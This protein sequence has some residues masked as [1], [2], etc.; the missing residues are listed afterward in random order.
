MEEDL[1]EPFV[2][3]KRKGEG[4]GLGLFVC[5]QL[6][7]SESCAIELLPER[8]EGRRRYAFEIDLSGAVGE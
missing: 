5:Q 4:R 2:T 7:E 3:M 8:N 6:L 1:F